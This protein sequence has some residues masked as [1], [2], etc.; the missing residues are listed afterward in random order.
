MQLECSRNTV[1]IFRILSECLECTSNAVRTHLRSIAA[2]ITPEVQLEGA[3]N[4]VRIQSECARNGFR[5]RF[6]RLRIQTKCS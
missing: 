5:I 1:G 6:E 4:A 3:L 2:R